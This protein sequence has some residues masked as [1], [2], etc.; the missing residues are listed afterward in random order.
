MS[1]ENEFL[2]FATPQ[3]NFCESA[4]QL[5]LNHCRTAKIRFTAHI[6]DKNNN[7]IIQAKEEWQWST[8]PIIIFNNKLI[9]GHDELKELLDKQ[10]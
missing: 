4:L 5:L 7:Q 8:V 3:C 9:G 6:Q 1:N 10:K 2:M